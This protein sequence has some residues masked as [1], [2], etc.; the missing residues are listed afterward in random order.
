M[1]FVLFGFVA[2]EFK[3]ESYQRKRELLQFYEFH[4]LSHSRPQRSYT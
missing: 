1:S 4:T 3:V 2:G